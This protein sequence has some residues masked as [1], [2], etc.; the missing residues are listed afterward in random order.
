MEHGRGGATFGLF[1]LDHHHHLC[2]SVVFVVVVVISLP[3][4]LLLWFFILILRLILSFMEAN[5][6]I[7]KDP[8]QVLPLEM[9]SHALS[10]IPPTSR[11]VA[12]TICRPWRDSFLSNSTLHT[13]LD[14]SKMGKDSKI[15]QFQ[16]QRS[17]PDSSTRT[18]PR[19]AVLPTRRRKEVTLC[20]LQKLERTHDDGA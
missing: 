20:S 9:F 7:Q 12:T 18:L 19:G 5:N 8:L 11:V 15:D 4:F 10:F 16:S 17:S 1:L 6:I 13:E 2:T 3:P 14:P